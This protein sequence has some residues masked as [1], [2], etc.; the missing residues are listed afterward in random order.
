MGSTDGMT[1]RETKRRGS[2]KDGSERRWERT[3]PNDL[4][5]VEN[6]LRSFE[7]FLASGMLAETTCYNALLSLEEAV[8]NV[9]KYAF[10]DGREHGIEVVARLDPS[11]IVIEVSDDGREFDPVSAPPPD[12]DLPFEERPVGG[13]GIHLLRRLTSRMAY[14]RAGGR[15]TLTLVFNLDPRT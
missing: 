13:L 12:F 6:A 2:G 10:A 1:R 14:E 4:G 9:I 3:I 15:N 5:K 7:S 11:E 8:T